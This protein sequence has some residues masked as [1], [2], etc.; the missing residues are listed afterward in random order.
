MRFQLNNPLGPTPEERLRLFHA[1]GDDENMDSSYAK[2]NYEQVL[3]IDIY[4][5]FEDHIMVASGEQAQE[6]TQ[7][8]DN[9]QTEMEHIHNKLLFDC[10]NEALDSF[11]VF[12]MKGMP[13][14][15][16]NNGRIFKVIL[17]KDVSKLLAKA[18][19]KV[20]EWST[21]M[22]GFIPFKDDSFMHVPRQLDE[23]TLNQIKEDRLVRLL[24]DEVRSAQKALENDEKWLNYE[25]EEIEVE[26]ELADIV[27]DFLITDTLECLLNIQHNR[28][29]YPL[30]N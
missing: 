29:I 28:E 7:E 9:F 27:F 3:D 16:K 18:S 21:F 6:E 26:I 17:S 11:R 30:L 10:L 4:F 13:L 25:D 5:D 14:P 8:L 19:Q 20:M 12:G 22:C 2:I 15:I 1:V 23:E 24:T